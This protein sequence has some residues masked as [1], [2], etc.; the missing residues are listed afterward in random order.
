[1]K[2]WKLLLFMV[3]AVIGTL[4]TAIG[5]GG[6][7]NN[8]AAGTNARITIVWP[9][10]SRLIP[11]AANSVRITLSNADNNYTQLVSRDTASN[12]NTSKIQFN[13]VVVGDY[14]VTATAFPGSDGSG[15]AQATGS[16]NISIL[17]GQTTDFT[18]TMDS[19]VTQLD[20]SGSTTLTVNVPS[21]LTVSPKNSAGD[22]VLVDP[23][24]L[25]WTAGTNVTVQG[26]STA[27]GSTVSVIA[28]A[29]GNTTVAVQYI[30]P[31]SGPTR[32]VNLAVNDQIGVQLDPLNS[33]PVPGAT[34]DYTATVVNG[35]NPNVTW[36]VT[37]GATIVS[38]TGTTARVKMP[39]YPGTVTV[40]ATSVQDTSR[41]NTATATVTSTISVAV[42][43]T[44]A[45]RQV[46]Q[47]ITV[48]ATVTN[49][50]LDNTVTWA[51]TGGATITSSS[52]TSAT[53]KMP[54]T[55]GSVNITARSVQDTTKT[56][57]CAV[58]VTT[59]TGGAS[60]TVR[61]PK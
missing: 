10:R 49:G 20:V 21:S 58:T 5:C 59:A 57:V 51:V 23:S 16:T 33:T 18:V 53:V 44:S 46:N 47:S 2:H 52:G 14:T 32:T 22:L 54:A 34:V 6:S 37:G 7:S 3:L 43:P 30:E 4:F 36:E 24:Q 56:A 19:T 12:S 35:T 28:S 55:T 40:K 61:S 50:N 13:N 29:L 8:V 11:L 42:T 39:N 38:S 9:E 27:T 48:T 17:Q 26:G 45:S 25:R 41:S 1:M 31:G 15:I 60:G